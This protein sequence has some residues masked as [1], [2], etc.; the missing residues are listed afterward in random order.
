MKKEG[1]V[2][3][4]RSIVPEDFRKRATHIPVAREGLPYLAAAAFTTLV[5]AILGCPFLTW[6]LLLLT[7]LMGHFFRDPERI[8][9]AEPDDVIAPAEGKV[10]AIERLPSARFMDQPCL[11]ISIFMSVFDVHVN[12]IPCSGTVLGMYYQ[13]GR[14]LAAGLG[15]ASRENEQNWVWIRTEAGQDVVMT[16]VAGLIARRIVCW[17]KAGDQVVRGE[18]FGMIR[19]G[20]RMDVYVPE[21]SEVLVS[22]GAHVYGG[23][24]AI[25]RL[26]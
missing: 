12:R 18:R 21:N 8:F 2:L 15:R 22:K 23:E 26:K 3:D 16:Q 10:I 19:F 13:K 6:P 20:S 17:P 1:G 5:S 14:F 24:T 9:T 4:S 7:L 25:C 11:K